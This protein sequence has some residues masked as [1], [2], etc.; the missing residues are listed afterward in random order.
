MI[1]S[2]KEFIELRNSSKPEDYSRASN[3][4]ASIAV[5]EAILK[6]H[7][8]MAKWVAHN[9]TI[10]YEFLEL[11]ATHDEP[12]VRSTVAMKNK[13]KE[14]LLTKLATDSDETVRMAVARH[15]KATASVLRLLTNDSWDEISVFATNRIKNKSHK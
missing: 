2:A 10:P 14:P 13:L 6:D 7:P 9:K 11:L 8:H 1:K 4:E 5:W 3:E 15:K 12:A